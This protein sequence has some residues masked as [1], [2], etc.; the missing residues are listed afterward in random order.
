MSLY[1]V[2]KK[3]ISGFIRR[4]YKV[5]AIG[6]EKMPESGPVLICPNHMSIADVII[7]GVVFERPI[8]F[9]AKAEL[10]KV[11]LVRHIVKALGAFPVD[12]QHGDVGAI[13]KAQGI[14]K[15]G[16]VLAMFPQ[17]TRCKGVNPKDTKIKYGAAMIAGH[18][19]AQVLPVCLQTK[20]FTV[21][22]FRKVTVRTADPIPPEQLKAAGGT[23]K[24]QAEFIFKKITDMIE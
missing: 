21:K 11:P 14:L 19:D 13:K 12:R 8:R 3:L 1:S 5:E 10:F 17:G 6:V 9:M 18:T 23:Y 15:N 24:E 22:P 4:F 2:I 20:D 16:E 7:L